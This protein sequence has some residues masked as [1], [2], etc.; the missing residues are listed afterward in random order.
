[1]AERVCDAVCSY[2]HNTTPCR[3]ADVPLI[4]EDHS[5]QL[6]ASR[7]YFPVPDLSLMHDRVG[8]DVEKVC[9]RAKQLSQTNGEGNPLLCECEMVSLAEVETI[10]KD[11]DTHSLTDIRLRTRMGMGTC[12]GTFCAIRAV[13][14]MYEHNIPLLKNPLTEIHTFLQ[15][16]WKGLR[17]TTWGIQAQEMEL[18][19]AIYAGVLGLDG[20][21]NAADK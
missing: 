19:R 20:G 14:A 2:L 9:E 4:E 10:A 1:M 13:N 17:S 18:T 7:T 16:R 15:E 12:Q 21:Y 11:P 6:K 5:E 8:D 3:T